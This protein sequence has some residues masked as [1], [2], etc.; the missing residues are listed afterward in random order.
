MGKAFSD[1]EVAFS[2]SHV[3]PRQEED[4]SAIKL[5]E[6]LNAIDELSESAHHHSM[7]V[8]EETRK[9]ETR[10]TL[11]AR[12]LVEKIFQKKLL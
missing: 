8:K 7:T 5:S 6:W 4:C 3:I 9:Q 10:T 1:K 2:L 12:L 11:G